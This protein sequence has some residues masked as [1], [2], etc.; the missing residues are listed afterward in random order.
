[1]AKKRKRR[2]YT[3]AQKGNADAM[4]SLGFCYANGQGVVKD[5]DRTRPCSA[6]RQLG[7]RA[8]V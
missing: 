3:P 7:L 6:A 8:S 1:M 2:R 4:Y 5:P